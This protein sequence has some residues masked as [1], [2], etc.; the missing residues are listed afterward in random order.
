MILP[1][2]HRNFG[3]A[4]DERLMG[5]EGICYVEAEKARLRAAFQL[6]LKAPA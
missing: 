4:R 2:P 5:A 1:A 3:S 6:P